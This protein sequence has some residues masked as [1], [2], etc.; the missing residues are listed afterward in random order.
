MQSKLLKI[1]F[2]TYAVFL[3]LVIV[4]KFDGSFEHIIALNQSLIE[5]EQYGVSNVNL[6]LFQGMS[7]YFMNITEPYAFTG[8]LGNIVGFV[9]FGFFIPTLFKTKFFPSM[10]ICTATI[11]FIESAQFIFKIGFFDVND[12]V[13]NLLGCLLGFFASICFQ[14]IEFPKIEWQNIKLL[15][16]NQKDT[17]DEVNEV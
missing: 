17:S 11:L 9:P 5:N 1:L 10:G 3:I 13:L 6:V 7:H 2:G 14:K 4:L 16:K 12:V 8:I 15:F